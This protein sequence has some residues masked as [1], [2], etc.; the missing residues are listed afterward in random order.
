MHA[1]TTVVLRRAGA[2]PAVFA[3]G[4]AESCAEAAEALR[5]GAGL[6]GAVSFRFGRAEA[7]AAQ[8]E[9]TER[10]LP[11][12]NLPGAGLLYVSCRE[13]RVPRPFTKYSISDEGGGVVKLLF[14]LP[15]PA[16]ALESEFAP[17]SFTVRAFDLAG[18][19]FVFRVA[20]THHRLDA[21]R[22]AAVA[23]RER[24][25]VTLQLAD[26]A[27]AFYSLHK[28][29]LIGETPDDDQP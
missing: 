4:R 18:E 3:L 5:R 6:R 23:Q 11:L 14:P 2:P 26:P 16:G 21:P 20:R 1:A 25:V 13:A 12:L 22:C 15:A 27:Q 24:L 8:L 28:V 10:S 9:L 19:D 29:K 7:A 17:R